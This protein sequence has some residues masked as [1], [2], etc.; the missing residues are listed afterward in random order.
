MPSRLQTQAY[1][2]MDRGRPPS[3]LPALYP[4]ADSTAY[5]ARSDRHDHRT[6]RLGRAEGAGT[7]GGFQR[8]LVG[9]MLFRMNVTASVRAGL[10]TIGAAETVLLVN[11]HHAVRSDKGCAYRAHL[12]TWRVRAVITKLGNEEVFPGVFFGD[13]EAIFC[14]E[15]TVTI[16]PGSSAMLLP[17]RCPRLPC[18]DRKRLIALLTRLH[19]PAGSVRNAS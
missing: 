15:K 12:R 1:C 11:H 16:S 13:R 14:C 7:P 10:N 8:A 5:E 6:R 18:L 3:C 4:A 2:D 19:R 17:D 9:H